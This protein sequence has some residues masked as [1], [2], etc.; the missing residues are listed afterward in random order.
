MHSPWTPAASSWPA[1]PSACI[2][3][4]RGVRRSRRDNHEPKLK[5]RGLGREITAAGD[6]VRILVGDARERLRNLPDESVQCVVTSPAYLG[7][8][9]YGTEPQVWGGNLSCRHVWAGTPRPAR[10]RQVPESKQSSNA[11]SCRDK[12]TTAVYCRD[13]G[14]WRGSFG[15]EPTPG[16]YIEHLVEVFR[17]I[18]RV[19]RKDGTAWLVIGDCHVTAPPG[20]RRGKTKDASGLPNSRENLEMRR[21]AQAR[22]RDYGGLKQKDLVMLPARVALA[23]QADGWWLRSDIIWAKSVSFCKTYSGSCMPESARDRPTTSHEHVFLLAKSRKYFFDMEAVKEPCAES[24][25]KRIRQR[26]FSK[27]H[28]GKKDYGKGINANRSARK[29]LENFAKSGGDKRHIRSVWTFSTQA[30]PWAH[31]A[32]FPERLVEPCVKAGTSE[33][34]CCPRCGAPWARITK[35]ARGKRH[36]ARSRGNPGQKRRKLDAQP[37]QA[38]G[39]RLCANVRNARASGGKH[40]NPFPGTE[41]AGWRP[42]CDCD[43]GDP[44]PCVVLDPFLGSGTTAL[45]ALKL[46]RAAVGV[47][48]NPEYAEMARRRIEEALPLFV[49][50]AA[51]R[52]AGMTAARTRTRHEAT[53]TR[54]GA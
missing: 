38:A 1:G 22:R 10:R 35:K 6:M 36:R 8:R 47:E 52:G 27:Q 41:T 37:K 53:G 31:F 14:A 28:G 20:N 30:S 18:W 17:E 50:A 33:K 15:Q 42:S 13:C 45:V 54:A 19:L 21:A 9:D 7:L 46:G 44:V 12:V 40:D 5:V 11:G 3:E 25:R 2:C 39:R 43:A 34:G 32:V 51:E 24:S 16:L 49:A 4:G 29:A 26:T 48:L 23:L